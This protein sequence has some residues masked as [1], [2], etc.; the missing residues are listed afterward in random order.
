MLEVHMH[1]SRVF[2]VDWRSCRL[3]HWI[4]CHHLLLLDIW[5]VCRDTGDR[6][7]SVHG[8]QKWKTNS[9]ARMLDRLGG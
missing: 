3:L 8:V 5:F 7:N 4:P 9:V 6:I 1:K 2:L